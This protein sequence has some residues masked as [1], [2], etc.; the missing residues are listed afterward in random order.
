M[1]RHMMYLTLGS[2]AMVAVMFMV[3]SQAGA[4]A[5]PVITQSVEENNLVTLAGNVRPEVDARY[6]RGPV[7]DYLPMEHMLLQLK[8]SP[9]SERELGN[10]IED[11]HNSSSPRFHHWLTAKQFGKRFGLAQQDL[12]KITGW[13]E[14]HGFTVN[15]VY[16]NGMLID[17]S[18]TAFQVQQAFHTHIHQLNV[19]GEKHIA[20]VS[21]PQIPAALAPAIAGIVSLNDFRPRPMYKSKA[22][23]TYRGPEWRRI[24]RCSL[25]SGYYL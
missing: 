11:L 12:E 20:N 8:R 17:F 7:P 10:F 2:L 4:A 5:V 21:N 24:R 3:A 19:E 13:L 1:S 23:F 14:S 16:D 22:D 18:G 6:D 9:E 25:R 15:V